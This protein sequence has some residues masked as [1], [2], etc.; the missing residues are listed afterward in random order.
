VH[1]RDHL[2]GGQRRG[3]QAGRGQGGAVEDDEVPGQQRH[4][5][6]DSCQQTGPPVSTNS[7]R[8][9]GCSRIA[10]FEQSTLVRGRILQCDRR[11]SGHWPGDV[12]S[13]DNQEEETGKE[14]TEQNQINNNLVFALDYWDPPAELFQ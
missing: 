11:R 2:R 13:V 3:G 12:V 5:T 9:R 6:P 10:R 14:E 8:Y 7:L 4:S 1:G